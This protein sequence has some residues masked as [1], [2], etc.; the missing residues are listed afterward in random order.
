MS[1]MCVCV[2]VPLSNPTLARKE[3][4]PQIQNRNVRALDSFSSFLKFPLVH[5]AMI[6]VMF[7]SCKQSCHNAARFDDCYLGSKTERSQSVTKSV[8]DLLSLTLSNFAW[9]LFLLFSFATYKRRA[10]KWN[11]C[12]FVVCLEISDASITLRWVCIMLFGWI[13]RLQTHS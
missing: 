8:E 13:R 2:C 7:F 3:R 5:A 1:A 11:A 12:V 6:V 9:P 4:N 10:E